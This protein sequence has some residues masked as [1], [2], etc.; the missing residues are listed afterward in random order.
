MLDHHHLPPE[1]WLEILYWTIQSSSKDISVIDYVPFQ[2]PPTDTKDSTLSI[3]RTL[4]MVCQLW[5]IW[6]VKLLYRNIKIRHGADALRHALE[7][8]KNQRDYGRMVWTFLFQ[9]ANCMCS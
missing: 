3:K 1:L 5:R 4:T 2:P 8:V 7:P 6:T 9:L